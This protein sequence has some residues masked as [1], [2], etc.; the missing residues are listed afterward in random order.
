MSSTSDSILPF[1]RIPKSQMFLPSC[2]T[3]TLSRD[4]LDYAVYPTETVRLTNLVHICPRD[5]L[6][7][8]SLLCFFLFFLW[9]SFFL[10]IFQWV[11]FNHFT[12]LVLLGL[13]NHCTIIINIYLQV[14]FYC[15]T[16][17]QLRCLKKRGQNI[18]YTL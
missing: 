3:N 15:Y 7:F 8:S 1:R 14:H 13:F 11:V 2:K 16:D 17:K 6:S 18:I 12:E 5:T 9:K 4:S 10:D